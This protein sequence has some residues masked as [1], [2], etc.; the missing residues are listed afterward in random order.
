[1]EVAAVDATELAALAEASEAEAALSVAVE[2]VEMGEEAGAEPVVL[3]G[4]AEA[5][6]AVLDL[7]VGEAELLVLGALVDSVDFAV[8]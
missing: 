6:T 7:S 4:E 3:T 2:E 8:G 1:M 5:A